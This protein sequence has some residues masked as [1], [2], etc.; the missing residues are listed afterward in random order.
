MHKRTFAWGT[1]LT[2]QPVK[3]STASVTVDIRDKGIRV[4]F[5]PPITPL[6]AAE[7]RM[8]AMGIMATIEKAEELSKKV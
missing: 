2:A 5:Q 8:F 4:S 6:R 3:G 1:R 7:G